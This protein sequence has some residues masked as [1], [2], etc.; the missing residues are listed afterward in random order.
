[1]AGV[2]LLLITASGFWLWQAEPT[3]NVLLITL[4]TTRADHIGC[5]GAA[6][7][8]T[9][10]LDRLAAAGV[11]FERAYTPAPLTLPTHASLMTGLYPPE[12][13]LITNGRGRLDDSIPTLAET[14]KRAG[15][16]TGAFVASFV[17]HSKFGLHRGFNTYDDD[18]THTDP[19]EYG[20]HRQRD[21]KR[22]VDAALNWLK[23]RR[24]K[25]FFCWVHLYDPHHPHLA[26]ADEFG[27]RFRDQP[28]DGEIA[29]VD[30]QVQRLLD[31]LKS[32]GAVDRT[33]IVVVGDHGESL[34]EHHEED[35]SLTLYDSVLHVPWIWAGR[36]IDVKNQRVSQPVSLVD[37]RPTLLQAIGLKHPERTSGRSLANA[38]RGGTITG[39]ECY[40]ATDDP[41]LEFGWSPLRSLIVDKWKYIRSPETELYD[42]AADPRELENLAGE[43]PER[44][45]DLESRL[46]KL[47]QRLT[48]RK[49]A[50][51]KLLPQELRALAS[52]GYLGGRRA[53]DEPK[54]PGE[55]LPDVKRML[56]IHNTVIQA[57]KLLSGGQ[58]AEAERQMRKLISESPDYHAS[59][60]LAESLTAQSKWA[61]SR[62]ILDEL[63]NRKSDR[64]D[65][66]YQIG[67]IELAQGHPE[68]AVAFFR[69][70]L[71]C[72]PDAEGVLYQLALTLSQLGQFS[73]S[74]RY[75]EEALELDPAFVNAHMGMGMVLAE[76]QRIP[77]A[78]D[79]YRLALAY[80]QTVVEAHTN[81]AVL[82]AGQQRGE[83]A[84]RHFA[85]A[86]ELAP[87][88]A[89]TRCNFG[90]YL[91]TVGRLDEAIVELSEA[92]RLNPDHPEAA[93][94]LQLARA[95]KSA[96]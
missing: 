73:E 63:V 54:S 69:T 61:E 94:R 67:V 39:E 37:L 28:Y 50:D 21:G 62:Q 87:E 5:Y 27:E 1:M 89:E 38:F 86:A 92:V 20:L 11:L 14:L 16:D 70:A 7:A 43:Q 81:L 64:S 18:L 9:P 34:G 66:H 36:G 25:P 58:P 84:G 47:E 31:H 29:Y 90:M 35:H 85:R 53:A 79:H 22:V 52:L 77:Q 83:E 17:L 44:I 51:V 80:D 91:M 23:Q 4:D 49:S 2:V 82:L 30:R 76:Q 13:G 3:V 60:V 95:R 72:K 8:L 46:A 33:L 42:L 68:Q 55:P 45:K 6:E 40:S 78:I 10:T 93:G 75:F 74:R 57:R 96:K 24:T 56:P 59:L 12:H 26:H 88:N 48:L 15:Y 41:L 19:T 71:Q 65:A 32:C